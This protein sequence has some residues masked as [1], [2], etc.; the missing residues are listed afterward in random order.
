LN[1]PLSNPIIEIA[2]KLTYFGHSCF[3][4]ETAGHRLLFDPFVTPNELAK[5]IGPGDLEADAILVSHG[6]FDHVADAVEVAKATGAVLIANFEVAGWFEGR[7]VQKTH[8][9]NLGGA[10]TFGFGRVKM[11]S[12]IHSS[13]LPD[14]TYGGTAGGFVVESPEGSFYYSGDSALTCD[15]K[16]IGEEFS[17]RFAVLPIGDNFTMGAADAAKAAGWVGSKKVV[18]VHYDTFPPIKIDREEAVRV[19]QNGGLELLLPAIG[20]TIEI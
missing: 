3:T 19:F 18:G 13:V 12:A 1:A 15:M 17:P 2:M 16:L 11:V 8:G 7:G 9:M 6:H 10:A 5:G 4:V 20:E 14:G